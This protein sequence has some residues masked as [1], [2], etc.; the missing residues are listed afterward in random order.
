MSETCKRCG[1]QDTCV[2]CRYC[3]TYT[4]SGIPNLYCRD[5][6]FLCSKCGTGFCARHR[7]QGLVECD[8]CDDQLCMIWHNWMRCIRDENAECC[9]CTHNKHFCTHTK[10]KRA[11]AR[12]A[13]RARTVRRIFEGRPRGGGG[14]YELREGG[15]GLR[16]P[17]G[18]PMPSDTIGHIVEFYEPTPGS[19][20]QFSTLV[21]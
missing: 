16:A 9:S 15:G 4:M 3:W 19:Q 1:T 2:P 8:D 20:A 7:K 17:D 11:A 5:C 14:R 13:A 6:I 21:M 18:G 10:S 12:A